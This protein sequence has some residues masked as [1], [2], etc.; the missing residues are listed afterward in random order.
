MVRKRTVLVGAALAIGGGAFVG[1]GGTSSS[2]AESSSAPAEGVSF[3]TP[4]S[5]STVDSSFSAKV[6]LNGFMINGDKVGMAP[7]DG[8]GHLHFSLDDG[9]YDH[10]EFSG[11]NGD[12]AVKLGVDGKYS[13]SVT[14]SIAYMN[15]PAGPHTLK[16]FLANNDHS[17]AGPT[18]TVDFTVKASPSAS[19]VSPKDGST[20]GRTFTAKVDVKQFMLNAAAVGMAP[21]AGEG[22]LHFSLDGGKYDLPKYSG[23]NGE[24]AK[25]LG[26]DG[27]Y[28]PSVT[29]SVTYTGIPAGAHTLTVFLANNDHSDTGVK[30]TVKFTVK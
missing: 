30:T 6:A 8:E 10:P 16:V 26:V 4:A 18:A 5:G 20:V 13:P 29:P 1:C 7:S 21:A 15:I 24:L 25:K 9:K 27:K 14:P 2:P 23:A 3:V 28:S 11:A 22:H 12:L 17:D 19:V